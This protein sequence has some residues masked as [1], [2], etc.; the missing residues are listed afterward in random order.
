MFGI[1]GPI[2]TL[3]DLLV[4]ILGFGL[5]VF[6]HECGHFFAA[7]WAGI[8]VLGFA[9]GFGP[10][11]AS[12]RKGMGWRR[13]STEPEYRAMQIRANPRELELVSP[14]EYRLNFLPLG[15]YVKMLGQDDMDPTAVS[16]DP[17][18]Y[19]NA[20]P[21]KRMIVISAG[22]VTNIITAAIL[23]IVV[24]MLGLK[25]E[26]P[27]VGMVGPASPAANA[28]PID[29]ADTPHGLLPGDQIVQI[30]DRAPN[31][32]ADVRVEVAM[33]SAKKPVNLVIQRPDEP[34]PLHFQVIPEVSRTDGLLTIGIDPPISTTLS[35]AVGPDGTSLPD[36]WGLTGLK[37]GT[38][39]ESVDGHPVNSATDIANIFASSQGQ[40]VSMV[41]ETTDGTDTR[42]INPQP[43]LQVGFIPDA[44]PNARIVVE[45]LLGLMPVMSVAEGE[46]SVTKEGRASGLLPGDIFAEI[47][48]I[49]FPSLDVGIQR[50]QNNKSRTIRIVV[51]RT[52]DGA[53]TRVDLNANVSK[54][55]RIGFSFATT[56]ATSAMVAIPPM[57][58]ES[59]TTGEI[60]PPAAVSLIHAPGERIVAVNGRPVHT[61][62]QVRQTIVDETA[63]ALANG[64]GTTLAISIVPPL[65][66]PDRPTLERQWF[67][68]NADLESIHRLSWAPPFS[69]AIFDPAEMELQASGPVNAIELG[70]SE[71]RRVV[72]MTYVTFAR[73]FQQTVKIQHLKGPVGIAH[74]G[75]VLAGRGFVWVLF[76][77]AVIS[78]NLAVINFLPLP[79]VDG[80]QFLMIVYEQIRGRPIPIPVQNAVTMAGLLL[81]VSLFLIITFNDVRNLLGL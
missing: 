14:T 30:N 74:I 71:T 2:G 67:V 81:I 78:V 49:E 1:P 16:N 33:A 40:P 65:I 29:D 45:H 55:G 61:L 47:D 63:R 75:T 50:I 41:F 58:I 24:F 62:T 72:V 38:K 42:T 23:F 20:K 52:I 18:S 76:F 11:I 70:L 37:P 28:L 66:N 34:D 26:P 79:I 43:E 68:S 3:L 73:L 69:L 57:T 46:S 77:M 51:L 8:R 15:G 48:G 4:V 60:A 36:P 80:G 17:D 22:V 7:R 32:F 54:Q 59:A 13:G 9:M 21:W 19:Q 10:A 44:K 5:I 6:L 56:A 53:L 64:D 12:Y 27:T 31:T 39:V 25:V 35:Q